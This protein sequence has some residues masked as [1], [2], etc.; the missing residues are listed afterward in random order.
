MNGILFGAMTAPGMQRSPRFPVVTIAATAAVTFIA[1]SAHAGGTAFFDFEDEANTGFSGGYTLLSMTD[2]GLTLDITRP[3]TMYFDVTNNSDL[4]GGYA[5]HTSMGDQALSPFFDAYSYDYFQGTFSQTVQSVSIDT[6]DFGADYDN[7]VF[8]YAYDGAGA[9]IDAA[10]SAWDGDINYYG[11]HDTPLTLTVSGDI[12]F[13]RFG[14][15]DWVNGFGNSLYW[16][17]VDVVIP[18]PGAMALMLVAGL[19]G[20]RRRRRPIPKES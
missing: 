9:L 14:G 19:A 4:A 3:A 1:S 15:G 20:N 10:N 2:N 6:G 12:A 13:I 11:A 18:G 8:L 7:V 16:D 5:F 17:N